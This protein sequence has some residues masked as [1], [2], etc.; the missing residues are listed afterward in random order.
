MFS[1]NAYKAL[2]EIA[3][4]PLPLQSLNNPIVVVPVTLSAF[5]N[6]S[7]PVNVTDNVSVFTFELYKLGIH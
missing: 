1:I 4:G 3:I 2:G 7:Q 5:S 6:L